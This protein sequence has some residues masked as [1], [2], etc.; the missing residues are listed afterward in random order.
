MET[1]VKYILINA[2]QDW[3]DWMKTTGSS[4]G[5]LL[6]N[7]L[8]AAESWQYILYRKGLLAVLLG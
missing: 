6:I 3:E 4:D 2:L 5:S 1:S 7:R 8:A